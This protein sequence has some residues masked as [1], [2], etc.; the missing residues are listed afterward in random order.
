MPLA[1]LPVEM[2]C[3]NPQLAAELNYDRDVLH[4][5]IEQSLPRLHICQKIIVTA[6]FN[7]I[8]QGE[9]ALLF[10]DSPSGSGKT[11]IYNVLLASVRWDEHVAIGVTSSGIAVFLL[12]GGWTS[13]SFFKIPIALGRDSM[14]SILVQSDYAELF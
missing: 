13:H 3:V 5:Y 14:C 8:A 1:L 6:M 4:G 10:L 9:G 7:A 11:F 12:E 2:F